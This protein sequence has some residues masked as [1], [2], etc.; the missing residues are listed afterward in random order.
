MKRTF[1]I[2]W[3]CLASLGA[4]AQ[5]IVAD[6]TCADLSA[7]PTYA[8]DQARQTLRVGYGHTS[9]GSQLV[10][11]LEALRAAGDPRWDFEGSGWGLEPGVFFNDSW[12]NAGGAEDLG[13]N[14]DLA[15]RDAT[16]AMLAL[17]DN[18]RNVVIWSWCGG[19]SDNTS[20]GIQAYLDAMDALESAHPGVRFVYMTGH[21]DGTGSEGNLHA[22]NEQIRAWCLAHDK[23]LFDFADLESY[24]PDGT[25]DF[26]ALY[27]TDGCEYDSDGDGNPWGDANWAQE[28]IASHPASE[29]AQICGLCG[30]CAHSERLNCV[31]KGAA[32]WWLLARL[33]GWAPVPGAPHI[34][35]QPADARIH[36]GETA[37]LSVAASGQETL[38]Y[39]WYEGASGDTGS[40]AADGQNPAFTSPPLSATASYWVRVSNALGHEDSRTATV[41]V[42]EADPPR[43][44]SFQKKGGPFRIVVRGGNFQ[45]GVRVFLA[46][47]EWPGV[48]FKG[49]D[50]LVLKGAGLKE[51]V[52]RGVPVLFRFL[53]PDGGETSQIWTR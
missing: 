31:R 38:E 42:S 18:D 29:F 19:V 33:A 44:D 22:R 43:V 12:G 3:L 21:L 51:Q 9:H 28:W 37:S 26:L 45:A 52:P 23:V 2:G 40:P 13:H 47:A 41:T 15:W 10:T 16:E 1:L 53:N 4:G 20:E 30:E 6:H 39:Q 46:G 5:A 24:D 32:F 50:R 34:T 27:G 36:P 14:G 11:G 17:P 49:E 7:V 25:E 8:L 48:V 35:L